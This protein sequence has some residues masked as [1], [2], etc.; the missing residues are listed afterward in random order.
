[1]NFTGTIM[2]VDD[3][4]HIRKF[5]TLILRSL[6]ITNIVEASNGEEAIATYQRINP[7]MVLLDVNMPQ[8]DG[9]ET[10]K[11]LRELDENAVVVML[12]SLANRHTVEQAAELGASNYIRKDTPKDEISKALKE[13]IES[14]FSDEEEGSEP[15]AP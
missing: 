6:G 7:D 10:L 9:I 15:A 12:T 5:V 4:A 8:I 14:I 2:I 11:R 3:E 1:M 13:T